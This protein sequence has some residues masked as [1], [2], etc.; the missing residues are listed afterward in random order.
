ML[1]TFTGYMN[2]MNGPLDFIS[3][4][5]RWFADSMNSAQRMFEILDAVP[6]ITE[7]PD[8]IHPE[9]IRGDIELKNVTFGYE[10]HKPVLK[11]ISM[12]IEPCPSATLGAC[13]DSCPLSQ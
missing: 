4:V 8:A 10:L 12:K 2:Q 3:Y 13:S 7:A 1:I 6:G 9:S 5:F 11:N